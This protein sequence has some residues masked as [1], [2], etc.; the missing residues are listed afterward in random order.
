MPFSQ[1]AL[2]RPYVLIGVTNSDTKGGKVTLRPGDD[3]LVVEIEGNL[4]HEIR[5]CTDDEIASVK[6]RFRL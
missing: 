5:E 2:D 6:F 1:L 4:P 3:L